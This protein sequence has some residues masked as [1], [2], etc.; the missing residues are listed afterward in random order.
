MRPV[1]LSQAES[2]WGDSR[3][4]QVLKAKQFLGPA[5]GIPRAPSGV[6]WCF[7]RCLDPVRAGDSSLAINSMFYS[8]LNSFRLQ[9]KQ[10]LGAWLTMSPAHV[11]NN[12]SLLHTKQTFLC[13]RKTIFSQSLLL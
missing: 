3:W 13:P 8:S 2:R 12:S 4:N 11:A 5:T 1:T 9:I 7:L 6:I 10:S